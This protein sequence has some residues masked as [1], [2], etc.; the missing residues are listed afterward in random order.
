MN[1]VEIHPGPSFAAGRPRAL[2]A[3]PDRVRAG[4]LVG[5]TFA[6]AP[7][8]QRFLMV[9]DDIWGDTTGTTLVVVEDFLKELREKLKK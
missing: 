4:A 2:F 3:V 6:I 7:D 1:V 8:D 5:G 9:R